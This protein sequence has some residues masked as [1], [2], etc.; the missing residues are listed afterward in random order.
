MFINVSLSESNTA[1]NTVKAPFIRIDPIEV[2]MSI[3]FGNIFKNDKSEEKSGQTENGNEKE[4]EQ[5][6]Y[7][8]NKI[9]DFYNIS[10]NNINIKVQET[11]G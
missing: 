2:D 10:I 7:L 3:P 1:E 6:I 9:S 8:K 11:D 5:I 4:S